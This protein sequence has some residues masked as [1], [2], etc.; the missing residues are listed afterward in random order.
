[1]PP[2][3][4]LHSETSWFRPKQ[5]TWMK[6]FGRRKGNQRLYPQY[7]ELLLTIPG[8]A[9]CLFDEALARTDLGWGLHSGLRRRTWALSQIAWWTWSFRHTDL[10]AEYHL[11]ANEQSVQHT[12]GWCSAYDKPFDSVNSLY[13]FMNISFD[14]GASAYW[15]CNFTKICDTARLVEQITQGLCRARLVTKRIYVSK[16]LQQLRHMLYIP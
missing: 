9:H 15:E 3:G 14:T 6:D 11:H 5:L 7:G 1:M 2:V 8:C 13:P 12:G 16:P 10:L 4:G